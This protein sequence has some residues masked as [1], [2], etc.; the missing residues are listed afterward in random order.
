V[1]SRRL[2]RHFLSQFVEN[3][4]S[5]DVDA[6]Q[7]L[8][9]VAAGVVTIP[10]F[11]TVFMSM[12]YLTRLLPA[13]GWTE[14]TG[15]EDQITFCVTSMLVAAA[16]AALEWDALALTPTD[17]MI[18]GVLPV[19]H[20]DLVRAKVLSLVLFVALFVI[21]LNLLPTV[22]HPALMVATLPVHLFMVP[23]LMAAHGL[24][25]TMAAAFGFACVVGLREFLHLALGPGAFRRISDVI[26]SVVLLLLLVLLTVV[27][28]RL[29]GRADWLLQ[30]G[31]P[32][33]LLRPI[34]WFVATNASIAG[35]VLQRVPERPM[36]P[37]LAAAEH[38]LR[39]RYE[40]NL[41]KWTGLAVQGAGVLALLLGFSLTMYVWNARRLHILSEG[42]AASHVLSLS[43]LFEGVA[44]A[45]IRPPPMRA[46]FLLLFRAVLGNAL[47][48]LYL[49]VALAASLGLFVAMAPFTIDAAAPPLRTVHLAAQTLM[50][51]AIIAAFRAAIRTAA[52]ER[53]GWVFGIAQTGHVA[54]F[55]NGVRLAAIV[56]TVV[57]VALLVPLHVAAWGAYTAAAHAANGVALGW[58]LVETVSASVDSPLIA[59]ISPNDGLNTVGTVFIGVI[60]IA[61][62]V[63]ARIERA[64]L[65]GQL[66]SVAFTMTVLFFA[67]C[68]HVTSERE[69]RGASGAAQAKP[70]V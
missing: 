22:L 32:P 56:A 37:E 12:R 5:T 15:L 28:V 8:A 43:R 20:R 69:H 21:A 60:V 16:V 33:I 9:L 55:R 18:L 17:S 38:Q 41:P 10:L 62:F 59:T 66:S 57:I 48:R 25:T 61:V 49:I 2:V 6:H 14:T 30:P 63:L 19:P 1:H 42:R 23:V 51:T 58:L 54:L 13:A 4:W 7:T 34:G 26:R 68:V 40:G 24:S 70:G 65:S 44:G 64:A 3:D 46:G 67:A 45:L 36:P 52:D 53:A 27:P 29:S 50:L 39:K 35:R 11:V 31:P 47:H